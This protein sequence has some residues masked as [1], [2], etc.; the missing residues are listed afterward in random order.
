MPSGARSAR[1]PVALLCAALLSS[2]LAGSAAAQATQRSCA[3]RE[4]VVE[5]LAEGYG[6][7]RK[8]IGLGSNNAMV[9][10]FASDTSGTWTITMTSPQGITCLIASGQAFETLAEHL[11]GDDQDA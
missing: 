2:A 6:E 10:V 1:L 8:S 4:V 11:P 9:E 3:P 7:T 5:R